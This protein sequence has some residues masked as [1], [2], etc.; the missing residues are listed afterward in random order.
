MKLFFAAPLTGLPSDPIAFGWQDG[1]G[2]KK[3]AGRMK[4]M[5]ARL[6]I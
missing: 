3:G 1:S 2:F 5:K 4:S 6:D